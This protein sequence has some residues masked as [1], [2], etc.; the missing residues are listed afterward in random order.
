[1]A[2]IY[3][4]LPTV[5]CHF[6]RNYDEQLRISPH[7]PIK[8]SPFTDHAVIMRG[9]LAPHGGLSKKAGLCYSQQQ[10]TNIMNGRTPDGCKQVI[11]R[12]HQKWPTQSEVCAMEGIRY[13]LHTE[14]FDFLC[15]QMPYTILSGEKEVRT[16]S[17]FSLTSQA[18]YYLQQLLVRDFRRAL[19]DWEIA[20]QDF[21]ISPDRIIARGHMETLERFLMRYEIPI[22][23][24]SQDKEILRRQLDRWL[25]D[26]R[27]LEKAYRCRE[28]EYEDSRDRVFNL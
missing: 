20:T 7:E 27:V 10:W 9:G 17:V 16:T 28:I 23:R 14:S 3:L 24:D 25:A 19:V 22:P 6:H 11:D 26:A 8:F 15:I 21:C 2:N 1:M 4:R 13:S 5:V 18:A 12:D